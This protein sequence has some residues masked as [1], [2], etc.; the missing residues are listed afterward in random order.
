MSLLV[1]HVPHKVEVHADQLCQLATHN[2]LLLCISNVCCLLITFMLL[3]IDQYGQ[4]HARREGSICMSR[5]CMHA[6]LYIWTCN[7]L[8]GKLSCHHKSLQH[9][10]HRLS[11]GSHHT[12]YA[13]RT[14]RHSQVAERLFLN[15]DVVGIMYVARLSLLTLN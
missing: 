13:Y 12:V 8:V 14:F 5:V 1:I 2:V 7:S 3:S 11:H 4:S 10:R 9:P 6:G 15:Q